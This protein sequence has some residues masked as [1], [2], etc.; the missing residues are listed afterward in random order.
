MGRQRSRNTPFKLSDYNEPTEPVESIML[1]PYANPTYG[2]AGLSPDALTIPAPQPDARPV[3]QDGL[4]A[5]P[6][7]YYQPPA[8][9]VLPEAPLRRYR[10]SPPGGA[11]RYSQPLRRRHRSIIPGLVG[12][13]LLLVQLALLA[14]VAC[15]LF[16]VQNTTPWLTLLFAAS[17]L[18]VQP[19][20]LLA[21]NINLSFLAGMPQL[22][23]ILEL[24]VAVLA[25]GIL[26][27]LLVRLLKVLLNS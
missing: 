13:F 18:F 4:P 27:R 23:T 8:Y 20:R 14:R 10:G 19:V 6:Y 17:D 9:P 15:I 2:A 16:S 25:Y 3:P 21:T 24:L 12:L 22:L 1:P 11:M 7:P 5:Y 26:S